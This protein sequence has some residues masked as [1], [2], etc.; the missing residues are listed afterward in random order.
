MILQLFN[1]LC[2][3]LAALD[4]KNI[5]DVS[6]DNNCPIPTSEKIVL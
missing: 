4:S 5:A 3:I 6:L 2:S 1:N